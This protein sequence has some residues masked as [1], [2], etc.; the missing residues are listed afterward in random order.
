MK[1]YIFI[2]KSELMTNLQY[3]LNIITH[4][5]GTF[6]LLFIFLNLWKY[7]YS[8]PNELING[9]SMN[10]MIWY[11]IITE[12]LWT[13]IGTRGLCRKISLDVK[14]GNIAYNLNKPYNYIGYSLSDHLGSTSIRFLIYTILGIIVG[15]LFLG[16]IPN[17][18]ILRIILIMLS[19]VL[20]I[21]INILFTISVGLLSF[22]IE[23]SNPI[24]W[25]Y[26][27]FILVLGVIFPIE[28]FPK[29][30]QPILNYSPIYAMSYG[31]AKLFVN[32]SYPNFIKIFISQIIYIIIAY[33]LCTLIYKK[34]V[35]NLNVNGG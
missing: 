31:P 16:T 18:N 19:C 28:Y 35:K 29:F 5:I 7:I 34:G 20:A 25:V 33:L 32:F 9:Y 12:I 23:D 24:Y 14:S 2:F 30:I 11:V 4:F 8:N 15:I 1:K 27:K 6:I 22:I 26:S 3:I 13:S 17:L 10:E 21:T